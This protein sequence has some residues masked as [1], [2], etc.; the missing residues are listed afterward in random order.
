[1]KRCTATLALAV[2][3]AATV[4]LAGCA[5]SRYPARQTTVEYYPQCYRPLDS[6]RQDE[7]LTTSSTVGGAVGGAFLGAL[8]GGLS[9]GKVEGA[10]IGAAA[11]GAAGAVGGNI[12]GKRQTA[13]RD[14]DYLQQYARSLGEDAAS[15]NRATAA[16]K[17]SMRCYDQQFRLAAEQYRAGRLSRMEFEERYRE[18]RSG[19][20][21][22]SA[23]LG[24]TATTMQERDRNYQE[25]LRQEEMRHAQASAAARPERKSGTSVPSSPRPAPQ[26]QKASAPR[27]TPEVQR[28]NTEFRAA[29]RDLDATR[30]DVDKRITNYENS[31]AALLG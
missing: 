30:Q 11:G 10:L 23:I 19:L 17:V 9:T 13:A 1:M 26:K 6:L 18:I 22:T 12:Y 27:T 29:Q 25:A 2:M 7:Q 31:V 3:I 5:G 8:I 24:S 15:M 21:E 4:P 16:A 14:A 28:K 20:Q